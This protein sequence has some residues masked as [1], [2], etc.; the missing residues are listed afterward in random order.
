M[1]RSRVNTTQAATIALQA[2][3]HSKSSENSFGALRKFGRFD[4]GEPALTVTR[5]N[6]AMPAGV[7]SLRNSKPLI[8]NCCLLPFE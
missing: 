8:L 3:E 6:N 2:A 5:D 1:I 7:L 4:A